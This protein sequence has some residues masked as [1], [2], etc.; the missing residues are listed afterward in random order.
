[1]NDFCDCSHFAILSFYDIGQAFLRSPSAPQP[2]PVS[3]GILV[4]LAGLGRD[5]LSGMGESGDL[6]LPPN[7]HVACALGSQS[8]GG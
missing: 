5:A 6:L 7:R 4:L 2:S 8:F 1:M 3:R